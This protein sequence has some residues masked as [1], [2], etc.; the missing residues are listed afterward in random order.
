MR[1]AVI[2]TLLFAC[3]TLVP[4]CAE[5]DSGTINFALVA[6]Q[7]YGWRSIPV[8]P[9][10]SATVSD[11]MDHPD[12][13][14]LDFVVASLGDWVSDN[15]QQEGWQDIGAVWQQISV[16][17]A[18]RQRIPWYYIIGNHDL[19]NYDQMPAG[20]NPMLNEQLG[21]AVA[22][23]NENCFAF[24]YNKVLFIGLGQTNVLYHLS[25]T[26]RDWLDYLT[27]TYHYST[28]VILTHQAIHET[29]GQGNFRATSWT[30]DDYKVY[31]NITW[32]QNFFAANPQV[33]LFLHGHNEKA[34]NTVAFDLHTDRWDDSC[35]FVMVPGTG[36][37]Y[38]QDAWSYIISISNDELLIRLWDSEAHA[39]VESTAA[40]VP[41]Q[42][43][44]NFP[45]AE[46]GMDW[47][48]IPRQVLD[49]QQ[50]QWTNRMLAEDYQ[51]ELIGTATT[52]LIDNPELD[53]CHESD[54][55]SGGLN[56]GYWYAVRGD[57]EALNLWT[58]EED[59]LI[60]IAG[61]TTLELAASGARQEYVEGKVPYNTGA[62]VPGKSYTFTADLQTERGEG[63]LDILVSIPCQTTLDKFVWED[64]VVA[65]G[66]TVTPGLQT[67]S[68]TFTVPDDPRA[69]FIQPKLRLHN[70]QVIYRWDRWS[71]KMEAEGSLTEDFTVH[72]N[73]HQCR[74]PGPLNHLESAAFTCDPE[75]FR[76]SLEFSCTIG[77][78]RTGLIR[79]VYLRPTLWSDDVS[80]G[81]LNPD[82]SLV[83]LEDSS[84]YN[85]RTTVMGFD[86]ADPLLVRPGFSRSE[87]RGKSLYTHLASTPNLDGEYTIRPAP[88]VTVTAVTPQVSQGEI[89]MFDLTISNPADEALV[90]EVWTENPVPGIQDLS[91]LKGPFPLVLGPGESRTWTALEQALGGIQPGTHRFRACAGETWPGPRWTDSWCEFEVL[92]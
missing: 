12:L 46:T 31:N 16:H 47:F 83:R 68:V 71:L 77:G 39:F 80:I 89:L 37:D 55:V 40:G 41:Y 1:K 17:S 34:W 72:L 78:N 58:G 49:G 50:W 45:V 88:E 73:G 25:H 29:T 67:F 38:G 3:T 82:Q 64:R 24:L 84:P 5:D 52:E 63:M 90:M 74:V 69:W 33:K 6:D 86:G 32:W 21:R 92:P 61:G 42:R 15:R 27:A 28:T 22:G 7:H 11:W 35:T 70:R 9:H 13:P 30:A 19:T 43:Q 81:V 48:S 60:R 2:F 54:E 14:C 23:M 4:I 26:Q 66:L 56:G 57:E 91:P 75:W 36:K 10:E 53:G 51:L 59:G 20:G 44:G 65:G 87:V 76:N 18:N 79:L 85:N 62:A 8:P